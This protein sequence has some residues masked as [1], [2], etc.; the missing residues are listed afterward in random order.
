MNKKVLMALSCLSL[1]VLSH[2]QS[3]GQI[4]LIKDY[5]N[6]TSELIG[7]KTGM[8]FRE[9]GFSSLYPIPGTNGKE[10]WTCSDRGVNVDCGSANPV[11]CTPTY[12]KM[13]LFPTY[14]PKIHRIRIDGDSV[15]I[16]RTITI[17]RPNGTGATG[18]INPTGLGS[19]STEMASTDT[20]LNCANFAS[21]TF[22]KDTFGID[23]EGI[24][25]DKYGNFWLC[26]EGGPTVW[27]LDQFGRVMKRFTPYG[28]LGG[29]QAVDVNIDTVFKY[30]KNNRGFESIAITPNG[31]IYTMIQSPLLYPD[32]ATGNATR[33]HRLLEID[34]V[35]GAQ[36]M[37]VY[38]NEGLVGTGANQIRLSDWKTG[39][40]A[41]INDSTFLVIEAGARGTSDVKKIFLININGA[42]A[43]H[44][45]LYGGKTA[46][47][48]VDA[49]GLSAQ[50]ITP[51]KKTL[52]LDLLANGWTPALDKSEGLAIIND[53]TIAVGNDN[54]YGQTC[55]LANGIPLPTNNTCHVFTY[56]L[57]GSN[58]LSNYIAKPTV[59]AIGNTGVSSSQTPYVVPTVANA[60]V[61]SM[62]TTGDYIGSYTLS[63]LPDGAGAFDNG[64]GTFTLVVN[65]ETGN[66][67]GATH[68][69]GKA[70]SFVSKWIINKS[71]LKVLS[72]EDLMK[73][74]YMYNT[75]SSSY[76]I[77]STDF[78]RFCS[79]DVPAVSAFYN[80]KT[81]K[82]TQSRFIMNG[83]E[84]GAEGR[85]MAHIITGT[86]AGNSYELPYLGKCSWENVVA[87]PFE[88]DSTIVAGTDDATPGQ[89]YIYVGAKQS[90]GTELEKAGLSGGTLYGIAVQW[91]VTETSGV[92]P[93]ANT[94]FRLESLGK[95]QNL[96]G[97][98]IQTNSV[99]RGITQFLRPEDAAWDPTYPND[100]YF[101]T[102]NGFPAAT[103]PSRMW[104]ARF[105]DITKPSLGGT[106]TAVLDGTEGQAMMDNIGID[107][108]GHIM[109]V[110]DVGNQAHLGKIWQYDIATDQLKQ[111][112]SHDTV[113]FQPGGTGFLTQDEEAS[114]IFDAEEILGPGM[115]ILTDQ[116]HRSAPSPWVEDGQLLT[117]YNPDNSH[118]APEISVKGNN[119]DIIDGDATPAATDNTDFGSVNKTVAVN[120][121]F[122]IKN[123]GP[124]PL[125][126]TG[127][128]VTG[129]N[130]ADFTIATPVTFPVTVNANDSAT[131]T[132]RF[133]PS[134]NGVRNAKMEILNNDYNER[135]YDF[136]VTGN[137]VTPKIN[138]KGN[139]IDINNGDITPGTANNTDFGGI[140]L[141]QSANKTFDITNTGTGTL[142][143]TNITITGTNAGDF[144]L[145]TP[146]AFPVVLAP[147][148]GQTITAKFAPTA[149]GTRSAVLN[150]AN[151]DIDNVAFTFAIEGT[152]VDNTS[153]NG[154]SLSSF[155][156]LYPNPTGNMATVAMNLAKQ[157]RIVISVLDV[158]GKE[159]MPAI[160]NS[161]K[162]GKQEVN[163]NT[164]A[165]AN[166]VY[167]VQISSDKE[168]SRIKM[169]VMH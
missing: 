137:S 102:T 34:P 10:F 18:I 103:N 126:I 158:K 107:K 111:V 23:P 140:E 76:S 156:K 142:T 163:I 116:A 60:V 114:G 120:K 149:V 73:N 53:S 54:D 145:V 6:K 42:T 36:R 63:G 16:L 31:K 48:L 71:D 65:H 106:I 135:V 45:G 83:E 122:R 11:G 154:L 68:A 81:S 29:K 169:V 165:L 88:Q 90:T 92:V 26:E 138:V 124:G 30:R 74:S 151:D 89:V 166:G 66:G 147:S 104:R 101:V 119:L 133:Q 155:A 97:A 40:M 91:M 93:A 67:A 123:A 134:A 57:K 78:G 47:G 153:I 49:T 105:T 59:A 52:F 32:G 152:G 58:K 115:W 20:V 61:T 12:D 24:A 139:S 85:A 13:Y 43:I 2:T 125:T 64:N 117:F 100:L 159:V 69:H 164:S 44:S 161:Y 84:T 51:V 50:G 162:A 14:A 130:A 129:A 109:I 80:S 146:P 110:E 72:G 38:L 118:T 150:I 39:D 3:L 167:Y 141:T 62:L 56:S 5:S 113:R 148:A 21:K 4:A 17:K 87:N 25:I 1:L 121:L 46:E 128:N 96:T 15:Q 144:S 143:I 131:L 55:P 70:G 28:N 8:T 41:A 77:V 99:N 95:V 136:A 75:T 108:Y 27:K 19:T 98:T 160:D 168:T 94:P 79:G 22:A 35:T 82:G 9:G 37:F 112:G 86:E 127:I 33:V 157:E 7:T 132:V